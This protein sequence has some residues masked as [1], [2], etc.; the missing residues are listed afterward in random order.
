MSKE[1]SKTSEKSGLPPGTL[2]HIGKVKTE[3]VRLTTIN[4][5]VD[6]Y[7]QFECSIE[8]CTQFKDSNKFYWINIDGLQNT[9]MI[10][11][12]GKQLNL[13]PLLLEDILNTNHRPKVEEYDNYLFL[14]LKM[15]GIHKNGN[16]IVSEQVSFV[17]GNNWLLSFQEQQGDVFDAIR[18][19][20][21]ENKGLIRQKGV[22]YLLYSL[23]DVIV[24]NY[25]FVTEY[26]SDN[27]EKLEEQVLHNPSQ[28]SLQKIQKLKRLLMNFRK[29]IFPL[30]EAV[31]SLQKY[32]VEL[33][34][35]STFRYL[36]DVYEHLI[37]L[38][39]SLE[40]QRDMLA[41]IMDLYL[42]GVSN[43][44]NEVMKVLTI[45]ATIFIPLTFIAGV[46]GMNFENMPE[47]HWKFGYFAI[48][49]IMVVIAVIMIN[50]FKRKKWL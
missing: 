12:I 38:S 41:S 4:Y 11:K 39:D 6:E 15:L 9:E 21:R 25:F 24:D 32:N 34:K 36:R 20:L 19:R 5:N 3:K 22:D 2:I 50:Y 16:K 27:I 35:E 37:H 30:R 7:N 17:L 33:I 42:S 18:T 46:Y 49:G 8:E 47:L 14:T 29:S 44:M 26:F 45:I 28:E 40:S 10:G 43:K 48:W 1:T 13:H 23:I 31:A